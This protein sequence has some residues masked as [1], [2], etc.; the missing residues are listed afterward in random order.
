MLILNSL[1]IKNVIQDTDILFSEMFF[2]FK[3]K[4][5]LPRT[6]YM[7]AHLYNNCIELYYIQISH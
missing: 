6:L 4:Q 5:M 3:Y 2:V 7:L 1:S